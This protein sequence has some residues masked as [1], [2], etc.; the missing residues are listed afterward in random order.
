MRAGAF[1]SRLRRQRESDPIFFVR[2]LADV[3]GIARLLTAEVVRRHAKDDEPLV[4]I[5]RPQR[6]QPGILRCV[7]AQRRSIDDQDRPPG[8]GRQSDVVAIQAFEGKGIGRHVAHA[9]LAH[10]GLGLAGVLRQRRNGTCEQCGT[11]GQKISAIDHAAIITAARAP[12]AHVFLNGGVGFEA[13]LSS[14]H[15]NL[16]R[17][18]PVLRLSAACFPVEARARA[19]RAGSFLAQGVI[20]PTS[21]GLRAGIGSSAVACRISRV[22]L[23]QIERWSQMNNRRLRIAKDGGHNSD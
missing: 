17:K 11:R 5:A 2:D 16:Q 13:A 22:T 20:S 14:S 21:N 9:G 10:A 18:E 19:F 15:R 12:V 7:T 4:A 6:L 3:A 23:P 1:D 8:K